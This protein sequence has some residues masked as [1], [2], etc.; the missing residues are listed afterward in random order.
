MLSSMLP[1]VFIL[2][3]LVSPFVFFVAHTLFFLLRLG[4]NH[5]INEGVLYYLL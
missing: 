4:F 2:K 3:L 5:Q 1:T